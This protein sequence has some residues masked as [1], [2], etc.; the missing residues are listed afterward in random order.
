[1]RKLAVAAVAAVVLA[2][3]GFGAFRLQEELTEAGPGGDVVDRPVCEYDLDTGIPLPG[4]HP[5]C[6]RIAPCVGCTPI[7]VPWPTVDFGSWEPNPEAALKEPPQHRVGDAKDLGREDCP[8]GW[9]ALVSDTTGMSLCFPPE[10]H[11]YGPHPESGGWGWAVTTDS[12]TFWDEAAVVVLPQ[13]DV[14]VHRIG[15]S[16]GIRGESAPPSNDTVAGLA[17]QRYDV[18]APDGEPVDPSMLAQ[19]WSIFVAARAD[20]AWEI[21]LKVRSKAD[22]TAMTAAEVA[23]ARDALMALVATV[24]VP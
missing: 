17:V 15:L 22:G 23:A 4:S 14:T 16:G 1:M 11:V 8:D 20:G 6:P 3:A 19:E 18:K 2:S 12:G 5:M 9:Q 21:V 10:G 7:P 24:R 13:G